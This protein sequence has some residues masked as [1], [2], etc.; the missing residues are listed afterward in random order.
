[1][2]V[3]LFFYLAC[4]ERDA[5]VPLTT[6]K[7][8]PYPHSSCMHSSAANGTLVQGARR[9]AR[10]THTPEVTMPYGAFRSSS[11]SFGHSLPIASITSV[12]NPDI[13]FGGNFLKVSCIPPTCEKS[14]RFSVGLFLMCISSNHLE[15][16][17]Y[18]TFIKYDKYV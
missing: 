15:C 9:P 3:F 16:M 12:W 10:A 7:R 11:R 14:D 17:K 5:N 4:K 8:L 1:M 13:R 18:I 6:D 2:L